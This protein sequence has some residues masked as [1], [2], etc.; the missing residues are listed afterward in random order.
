MRADISKNNNSVVLGVG[1]TK[2]GVLEA[3][4]GIERLGKSENH[5]NRH[6]RD[7]GEMESSIHNLHFDESLKMKPRSTWNEKICLQVT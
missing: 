5:G 2:R 7:V 4:S 3:K 1:W 6:F